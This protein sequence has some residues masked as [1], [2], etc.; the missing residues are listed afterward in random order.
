[1]SEDDFMTGII[2]GQSAM[3]VWAGY[4]L[5]NGIRLV[6]RGNHLAEAQAEIIRELCGV[7]QAQR[8]L[9][10]V[11]DAMLSARGIQTIKDVGEMP[12]ETQAAIRESLMQALERLRKRDN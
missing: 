5:W 11:Q 3:L 1:M 7:T 2:W 4:L 12:P 10:Q 6:R 8:S 9:L